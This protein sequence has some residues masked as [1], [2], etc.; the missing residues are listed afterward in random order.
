MP[1]TE[2]RDAVPGDIV[3]IRRFGDEHI[4]ALYTP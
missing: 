4:P 2:I 3:A 1:S